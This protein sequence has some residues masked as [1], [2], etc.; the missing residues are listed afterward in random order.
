VIN[1]AGS[2]VALKTSPMGLRAF[3]AFSGFTF[4]VMSTVSLL[5]WSLINTASHFA[6]RYQAPIF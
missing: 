1:S 4:D 6:E 5:V 2:P 3:T